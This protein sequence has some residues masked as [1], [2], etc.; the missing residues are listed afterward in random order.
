[1]KHRTLRTSL[2]ASALA[3][4]LLAAPATARASLDEEAVNWSR[5]SL[6]IACGVGLASATTGLGIVVA[7]VPCLILTAE[8]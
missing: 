8:P 5:I 4:S 6:F 7:M 2:V 3:L 1:L